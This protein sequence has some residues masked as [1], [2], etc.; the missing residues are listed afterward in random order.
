M[1]AVQTQLVPPSQKGLA[2][3]ACRLRG[4]AMNRKMRA[5]LGVLAVALLAAPLPASAGL[6]GSTVIGTPLFPDISTIGG[7]GHSAGPILVDAGIEFP[8]NLILYS[9]DI[10]I[11]DNQIL[12]IPTVST[13]YLTSSFNGFELDFFGAPDITGVMLHPGSALA[14]TSISF[15]ADRVFLNFSGQTVVKGEA[16]IFDV[17]PVPEP[18]TL[19]LLGIGLAG[20]GFSRRRKS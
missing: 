14:A 2:A 9:G 4:V 11:T 12:W 19:A 1:A 16:A 18:V 20:L 3:D 10:D 15:T 7:T 17:N 5:F 6:L 13:T 8:E